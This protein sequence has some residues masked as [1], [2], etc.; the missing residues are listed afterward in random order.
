MVERVTGIDVE[1]YNEKGEHQQKSFKGFASTVFL[2]EVDHLFG[3][4]YVDHI[5]DM[6]QFGFCDEMDQE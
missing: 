1:Y 3:K 6:G 4:L 2:H 5:K